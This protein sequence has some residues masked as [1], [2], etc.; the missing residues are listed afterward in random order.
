MEWSEAKERTLGSWRR[1]RDSIGTADELEL[2][3]QINAICELCE[4]ARE[5]AGGRFPKCDYCLASRQFGGCRGINAEMSDRV[6]A[7]DWDRLR[8]LV[9]EFIAAL[10]ELDTGEVVPAS[11]APGA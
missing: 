8:D 7:K 3:V 4:K 5:E 11:P 1:L 9:D 10:L 6:A 2:L